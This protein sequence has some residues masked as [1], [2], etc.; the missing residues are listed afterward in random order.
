MK[1]LFKIEYGTILMKIK[2]KAMAKTFLFLCIATYAID[3]WAA[4]NENGEENSPLRS[5]SASSPEQL[6]QKMEIIKEKYGLQGLKLIE[7]EVADYK[8]QL[9]KQHKEQKAQEKRQKIELE[10]ERQRQKQIAQEKLQQIAQARQQEI[11]YEKL[12]KMEHIQRE[13]CARIE[14]LT[15]DMTSFSQAL[16]TKFLREMLNSEKRDQFNIEF[17]AAFNAMGVEQNKTHKTI[18]AINT[19]LFKLGIRNQDFYR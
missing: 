7:S 13:N 17:D 14:E 18:V 10:A 6:K 9:D 19:A 4:T 11:E 5:R 16:Y 12:R 8:T 1:F 15:G 2:G 3:C